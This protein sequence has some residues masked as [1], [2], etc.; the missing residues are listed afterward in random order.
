MDW[1]DLVW[2]PSNS[3]REE[4]VSFGVGFPPTPPERSWF[5][6]SWGVPAH[7]RGYRLGGGE[8]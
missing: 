2:F 5:L 1:S 7:R 8:C 6:W 4:L 3:S